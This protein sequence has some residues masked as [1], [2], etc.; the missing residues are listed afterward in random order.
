M[1]SSTVFY[2]DS[3]DYADENSHGSGNTELEAVTAYYQQQCDEE[4]DELRR[5]CPLTVTKYNMGRT[6][7]VETLDYSQAWDAMGFDNPPA[8]ARD[9]FGCTAI[10][11]DDVFSKGITHE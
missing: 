1:T 7:L 6:V 2:C 11:S 10:E 3:A 4:P 8:P 5:R 9:E